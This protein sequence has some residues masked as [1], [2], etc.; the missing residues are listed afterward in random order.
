MEY[1]MTLAIVYP[2][3]CPKLLYAYSFVNTKV[4]SVC[5]KLPGV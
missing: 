3:N 2:K 5:V 4:V 1:T